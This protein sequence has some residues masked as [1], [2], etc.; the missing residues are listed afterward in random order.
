M[1][2]NGLHEIYSLRKPSPTISRNKLPSKQKILQVSFQIPNE[3]NTIQEATT[4]AVG[5]AFPFYDR[6]RI[7]VYLK[8]HLI[9][10]LEVLFNLWRLLRNGKKQSGS[11]PQEERL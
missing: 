9:K 10:K 8:K 4:G 11:A 6:G 3:E 7:P 1:T 5:T 2:A